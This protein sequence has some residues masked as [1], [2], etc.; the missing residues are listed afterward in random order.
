MLIIY[1]RFLFQYNI[2]SIAIHCNNAIN[3]IPYKE[4][5]IDI[6]SAGATHIPEIQM[7]LVNFKFSFLKRNVV[8]PV[9]FVLEDQHEACNNQSRE[10]M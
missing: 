4:L 10:R 1:F 7:L 9:G 8:E 2:H 5:S 3:T 6:I